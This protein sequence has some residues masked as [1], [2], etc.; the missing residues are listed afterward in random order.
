MRSG[1]SRGLIASACLSTYLAPGSPEFSSRPSLRPLP[2]LS[3][4]A[5]SHQLMAPRPQSCSFDSGY[6]CG[7]QPSPP[8]SPKDTF[9]FYSPPIVIHPPA[10]QIPIEESRGR[11]RSR[12]ISRSPSR[13]P[14]PPGC[15]RE[16]RCYDRSRSP[17]RSR[18]RSRSRS[19]Y[20][21]Y[22]HG[23]R[24][25]SPRPYIPILP[26]APVMTPPPPPPMMRCLTPP[27]LAPPMMWPP[28]VVKCPVDIL[29]FHNNKS[30]AYAP[31]AKTYDVRTSSACSSP[32]SASS[33][34][35]L[36]ACENSVRRPSISCRTSGLNSARSNAIAS[37][38]L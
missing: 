2:Q 21:P 29:T 26:P 38:C 22:W 31:A 6:T 9:T 19:P 3:P 1:G 37:N 34:H 36:C 25:P 16:R 8:S 11:N 5:L 20:R 24:S 28:P 12:S 10:P 14:T 23:S 32:C 27:H 30:M 17:S 35:R 13:S 33:D 7:L 18:S 4:S 15:V